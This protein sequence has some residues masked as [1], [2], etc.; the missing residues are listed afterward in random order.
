VR[1]PLDG[2]GVISYSLYISDAVAGET[3]RILRYFSNLNSQTTRGSDG[4]YTLKESALAGL[5]R[6]YSHSLNR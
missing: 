5:R 2:L 6:L 1:S 3:R 4:I